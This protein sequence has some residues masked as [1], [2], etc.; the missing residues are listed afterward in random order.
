MVPLPVLVRTNLADR[1]SFV[2]SISFSSFR[3][4]T[5]KLSCSFFSDSRRFFSIT[6]ALIDKNTG[7]GIQHHSP[8]MRQLVLSAPLPHLSFESTLMKNG[9]GPA[10]WLP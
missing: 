2:S 10:N 1:T 4:R 3:L 7:R 5:L 8:S 6:S 9:G